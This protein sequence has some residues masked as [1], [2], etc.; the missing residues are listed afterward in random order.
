MSCT[1]F[2]LNAEIKTRILQPVSTFYDERFKS[3]EHLKMLYFYQAFV[4]FQN[5]V[6]L[7]NVYKVDNIVSMADYSLKNLKKL[8]NFSKKISHLYL[9]DGE[10]DGDYT[11][12][13]TTEEA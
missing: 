4:T 6:S 3:Y 12:A 5:I 2:I 13:C 9:R 7:I 10:E 11:A 8:R 1:H